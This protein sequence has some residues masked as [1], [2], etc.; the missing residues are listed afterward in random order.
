MFISVYYISFLELVLVTRLHPPQRS[1]ACQTNS[2]KVRIMLILYLFSDCPCRMALHLF[3]PTIFS[4]WCHILTIADRGHIISIS[5]YSR[6]YFL[7]ARLASPF[8]PPWI[9]EDRIAKAPVRI[10]GSSFIRENG[11]IQSNVPTPGLHQE[12]LMIRC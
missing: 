10:P 8:C 4:V 11:T 5:D 6:N 12:T 9:G 7:G 1:G 3:G 2:F